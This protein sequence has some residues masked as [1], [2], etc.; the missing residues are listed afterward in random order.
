MKEAVVVRREGGEVYLPKKIEWRN[1]R[2]FFSES[3]PPSE[4]G[5]WL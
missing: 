4:I 1:V 3:V 2:K 5:V